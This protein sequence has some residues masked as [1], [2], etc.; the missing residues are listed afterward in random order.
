MVFGRVSVGLRKE[1]GHR[2]RLSAISEQHS[3]YQAVSDLTARILEENTLVK[4]IHVQFQVMYS[5]LGV[6]IFYNNILFISYSTGEFA[7]KK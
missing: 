7:F 1:C 6:F 5:S 2:L 4:L 3:T